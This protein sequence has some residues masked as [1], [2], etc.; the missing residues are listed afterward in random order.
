MLHWA[1]FNRKYE[2]KFAKKMYEIFLDL[3]K[4]VAPEKSIATDIITAIETRYKRNLDRFYNELV[5]ITEGA[6]EEFIQQHIIQKSPDDIRLTVNLALQKR[7]ASLITNMTEIEKEKLSLVMQILGHEI[8]Y[9]E[10]SQKI[11]PYIG[12]TRPQLQRLLRL[13]QE[14]KS[15]GLPDTKIQKVLERTSKQMLRYRSLMIARTEMA[16]TYTTSENVHMSYYQEKAGRRVDKIW[17][18]SPD[19][20]T[21]DECLNLDNERVNVNEPFSTGVAGPPAHPNCRCYLIYEI[22]D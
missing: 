10:F 19:D 5:D 20:L 15:Q 9:T 8:S 16:Y 4:N 21:C 11:R 2:P 3:Q 14:L 18:V 22:E 17:Q 6:I 13:E 7:G 12:L 1:N